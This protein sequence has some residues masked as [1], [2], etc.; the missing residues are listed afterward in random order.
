MSV[1]TV[2]V[3]GSGATGG[4]RR[5]RCVFR[6]FSP[7]SPSLFSFFL[8][9][10]PPPSPHPAR[11]HSSLRTPRVLLVTYTAIAQARPAREGRRG[12]GHSGRSSTSPRPRL[13]SHAPLLPCLVPHLVFMY[14]HEILPS[15]YT[16]IYHVNRSI[17]SVLL[18]NF[19]PSL[20]PSR[21]HTQWRRW[22]AGW[23]R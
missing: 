14:I 3:G 17:K 9:L 5:A 11:R 4:S 20:Q 21:A 15:A 6:H 7:L 1:S 13:A 23:C 19:S 10:P 8:F 18:S 12:R 16:C 2:Y 22:P